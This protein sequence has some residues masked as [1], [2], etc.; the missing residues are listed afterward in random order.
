MGRKSKGVKYNYLPYESKA[1]AGTGAYIDENGKQQKEQFVKL[2]RSMLK[3]SAFLDLKPRAAC[4]YMCMRD[5]AGNK[6]PFTFPE[7]AWKR[8][9]GGAGGYSLYTNKKSFYDDRDAL[10]SHGFIDC[11]ERNKTQRDANKYLFSERW[12][13]WRAEN[14][15]VTDL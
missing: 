8:G 12:K 13:E 5:R 15:A 6:S 11:A 2:C 10:I 3:S 4:L 14:L 7:S 9:K 1:A